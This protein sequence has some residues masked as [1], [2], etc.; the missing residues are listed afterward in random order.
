MVDWET[1]SVIEGKFVSIE[2][3]NLKPKKKGEKPTK[4]RILTLATDSGH[5]GIWEKHQLKILFD[6]VGEGNFVWIAHL[7]TKPIPG[8]PI[9]MHEFSIAMK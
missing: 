6:T 9:P 7:G 1:Q 2:D 3:V 4:T 5:L 8:R